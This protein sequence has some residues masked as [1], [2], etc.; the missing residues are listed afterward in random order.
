M[1][2]E[3]VEMR[4]DFSLK[5]DDL[6]LKTLNFRLLLFLWSGLM[7]LCMFFFFDNLNATWAIFLSIVLVVGAG[8]FE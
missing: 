7:C 4:S 2:A 5:T 1:A 3:K 8:Q 6:P